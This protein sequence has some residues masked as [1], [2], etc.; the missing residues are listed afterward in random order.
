MSVARILLYALARLDSRQIAVTM[1]ELVDTGMTSSNFDIED[2][3][4]PTVSHNV[5]HNARITATLRKDTIELWLT[6][7]KSLPVLAPRRL[8]AQLLALSANT[9]ALRCKQLALVL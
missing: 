9:S 5:K 6:S 8:P 4:A 2:T 1:V 3:T 7:L